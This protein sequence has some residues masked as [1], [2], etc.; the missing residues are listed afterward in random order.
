MQFYLNQIPSRATFGKGA[1]IDTMHATWDGS[2]A[3]LETEHG[4]IQWIFPLFEGAGMNGERATSLSRS[5]I[6]KLTDR[7]AAYHHHGAR[8]QC[9]PRRRW[10]SR[11]AAS[12]C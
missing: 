11:V 7:L 8:L 10:R 2:Y 4:Y 9:R 1:L 12:R 6:R 3:L 5:I